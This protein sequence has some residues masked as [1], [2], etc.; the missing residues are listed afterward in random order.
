MFRPKGLFRSVACPAISTCNLQNCL[1]SHQ[2]AEQPSV[3]PSPL[4]T[5]VQAKPFKGVNKKDRSPT[6]PPPKRRKIDDDSSK[7]TEA[8]SNVAKPV[9][10]SILKKP[11]ATITSSTAYGAEEPKSKPSYIPSSSLDLDDGRYLKVETTDNK[12]GIV[13]RARIERGGPVTILKPQVHTASSS[14]APVQG[15]RTLHTTSDDKN[16]LLPQSN[17]S[18]ELLN[19]GS[20]KPPASNTPEP[21]RL[22]PRSV[23]KPPATF[24]MRLKLLENIHKHYVRL[25]PASQETA[26]GRQ[27][28]I[29]LAREEEEAAALKDVKAYQ[30]V[31]KNRIYALHKMSAEDFKKETEE[32]LKAK[33]LAETPQALVTGLTP[34]DEIR[35]IAGYVH[36]FSILKSYDY[37]LIPPSEQDVQKAKDGVRAARGEEE[38]E[39]CKSRFKV[40]PTKD[41]NTGLLTTAGKCVHHHGKPTMPGSPGQKK[42]TCCQEPVGESSGCTE[43]PT[44]VFL[45]KAANRLASQWQF[46]ETPT[47]AALTSSEPPENSTIEK[48]IC[49][50]CEMGFTTRGLEMIRLTATRFPNYEPVIDILVQPFGEILDLNT[51]F[52]GVTQEQWDSA[53]AYDPESANEKSEILAKAVSPLQARE[54]VFKHIDSSTI[55]I[56]HSLENDMKCTRIIH[57][58]IVDTAILYR[59]KMG[60]GV[61][62]GLKVLVRIHL[63]RYIQATDTGKGHDSKEDANE[64]GNLVR[65]RLMKDVA[66]GKI[67][68][69]GTWAANATYVM[70]AAGGEE[71]KTPDKGKVIEQD[72]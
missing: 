71:N 65:K 35:A 61:R 23:P 59:H 70:N 54:I 5:A 47:A 11:V 28:V 68:K 4:P 27:R 33:R 62:Y 18:A 16:T 6:P 29:K 25:D 67:G 50:D 64:A 8:S 34:E 3:V 2:A 7:S 12:T 44:H 48:A 21:E 15:L 63:G 9:I 17:V 58:R 52:S 32:K 46:V 56:G 30:G 49:L 10:K 13:T 26:A 45:V 41:E 39:R 19:W 43:S 40:L 69:D 31:L 36:S 24:E 1:F 55:I 37:V 14:K 51:R 60:V 38:C 72:R 53:P 42:W 22:I 66:S 20:R 57:P